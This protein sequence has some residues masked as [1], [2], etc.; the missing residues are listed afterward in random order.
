[1]GP[2][3]FPVLAHILGLASLPGLAPM[4]HGKM[5]M[6]HETWAQTRLRLGHKAGKRR[7]K[8]K[9]DVPA[10]TSSQHMHARRGLEPHG[11]D[12]AR[13]IDWDHM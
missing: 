11:I 4:E 5:H 12:W 2:S 8:G 13:M 6:S 10:D 7:G 9:R 3:P 1:M